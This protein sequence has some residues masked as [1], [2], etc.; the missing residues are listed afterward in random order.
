[1]MRAANAT[2]ARPTARSWGQIARRHLDKE[3]ARLAEATTPVVRFE[4]AALKG[5]REIVRGEKTLPTSMRRN[6]QL[7]SRPPFQFPILFR[8]AG[9]MAVHFARQSQMR[10]RHW[11]AAG[12]LLTLCCACT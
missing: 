10:S 1:M 2:L 4:A 7:P 11:R 6:L 3:Q 9:P 8:L 5:F 12:S